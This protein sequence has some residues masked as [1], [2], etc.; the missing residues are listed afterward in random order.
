MHIL[1]EKTHN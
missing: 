1:K